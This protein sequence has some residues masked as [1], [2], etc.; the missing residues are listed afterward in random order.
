MPRGRGRGRTTATRGRAK[1]RSISSTEISAESIASVDSVATT[2]SDVSAIQ[3]LD[4]TERKKLE[5]KYFV[6]FKT[7]KAKVFKDIFDTLKENITTCTITFD[8]DGV[9]VRERCSK[10]SAIIYL[11][12][13]GKTPGTELFPYVCS[14]STH[15]GVDLSE[16]QKILK[17]VNKDAI[18]TM[19]YS[20]SDKNN[21]C[22]EIDDPSKGTTN[23][24][25]V[26][27]TELKN[28]FYVP[29]EDSEYPVQVVISSN[30]FKKKLQEFN[31][32][33]GDSPLTIMVS[34]NNLEF[35]RKGDSIRQGRCRV[36][37]NGIDLIK[38]M[39]QKETANEDIDEIIGGEYSIKEIVKFTKC[40]SL[41]S[42]I[43][44][45]MSNTKPL[46][47][48]YNISNMGVLKLSLPCK[49]TEET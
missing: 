19:N 47:M 34:E 5:D 4:D 2:S 23:E 16:I 42:Q 28:K 11:Y 40:S 45:L 36:K 8:Q 18:L 13:D 35:Q 14:F 49:G 17:T 15:I 26:A 20:K 32:I 31:S 7:V 21:F 33:G 46:V 25:Q 10:T 6:Y 22:I 3:V 27:I 39:Y 12:L 1:G 24:Y 37:E 38:V 44:L 43:V 48:E 29:P 9:K 30:F 41:S